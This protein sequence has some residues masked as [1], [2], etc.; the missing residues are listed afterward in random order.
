MFA[1]DG[2]LLRGTENPFASNG[3]PYCTALRF[4]T[5]VPASETVKAPLAAHADAAVSV[6]LALQSAHC[7]CDESVHQQ[8]IQISRDVNRYGRMMK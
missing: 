4:G 8:H 6:A 3:I 2:E 1:N 7:A 5:S